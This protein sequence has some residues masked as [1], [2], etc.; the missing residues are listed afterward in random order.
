MKVELRN[1]GDE[2]YRKVSL[3]KRADR[4]QAMLDLMY[5][6]AQRAKTELEAGLKQNP[7]MSETDS[8]PQRLL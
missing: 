2:S 1:I 4:E 8:L 6:V 5:T 7:S 3:G